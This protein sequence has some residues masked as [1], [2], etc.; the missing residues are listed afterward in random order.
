LNSSG[1]THDRAR[2]GEDEVDHAVAGIGRGQRQDEHVGN[3]FFLKEGAGKFREVSD[4]VG[5]EN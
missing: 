3:S 5:A 2:A 1:A 4:T